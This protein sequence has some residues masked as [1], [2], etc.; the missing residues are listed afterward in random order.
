MSKEKFNFNTKLNLCCSRDENRPVMNCIHFKDG[1]AYAANGIIAIKQSLLY[2]S[3]INPERLN[4]NSI[5]ADSYK[6]IT[7]YDIAECLD[8]GILCKSE[9]G[10]EAFFSYFKLSVTPPDIEKVISNRLKKKNEDT[11]SIGINPSYLHDLS[12]AMIIQAGLKLSFCGRD[13]VIVESPEY[14]EQIAIIMPVD[15]SN[16]FD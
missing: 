4:G 5:H 8:D 16:L 3:V 11:Q 9:D 2:H 15:F 12:K 10:Q 13:A 6:K 1:Y 14:E 7:S